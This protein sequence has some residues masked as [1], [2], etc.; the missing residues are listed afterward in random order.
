MKS[1]QFYKFYF[2]PIM[3]LE[4]GKNVATFFGLESKSSEATSQCSGW[5]SEKCFVSHW[6]GCCRA[7]Q[8]MQGRAS[9]SVRH[10]SRDY[11]TYVVSIELLG[12]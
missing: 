11:K 12:V 3:T 5:V 9:V 6:V 2:D 10:F 4:K 8:F 1:T 7:K